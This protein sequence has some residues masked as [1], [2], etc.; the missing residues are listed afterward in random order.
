[1]A[2]QSRSVADRRMV[3]RGFDGWSKRAHGP[4]IP[5]SLLSIEHFLGR[6]HA[7]SMITRR[8]PIC[9]RLSKQTI[10]TPRSRYNG[11]IQKRFASTASAPAAAP[12]STTSS[13]SQ[14]A[15]ITNELD[16]LSPRFRVPAD[17]IQILRSPSEFYE[18]FKVRRK[19][20]VART[21]GQG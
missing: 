7:S 5:T 14:L 18:T 12:A 11:A 3:M 6:R 21:A 13:A 4:S 17:S 16:K 10:R 1:M 15:V 20:E 2:D 19:C 8:A 9:L